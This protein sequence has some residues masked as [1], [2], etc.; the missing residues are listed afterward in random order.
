MEPTHVD[1]A[2][3]LTGKSLPLDHG[4]HLFSAVSRV[5]PVLH[6]RKSWGIHP[7]LGRR[8]GPGQLELT[9]RSTLKLRLPVAELGIAF[10]LVGK[11]LEV[12]GNRV[13]VGAPRVYPLESKPTLK[14]RFVT[15]KHH[16]DSDADFAAAVREQLAGIG[17]LGQELAAIEVV[18][19]P[20]RVMRVGG[21]VIVGFAV[22]LSGL[23]AQAS[24]R[25]QQ[26]GIGGRRHMG[27]GIFVPMGRT[28]P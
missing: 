5:L 14:A 1:A 13:N 11:T 26:A 24:L 15:I 22:S 9:D 17:D 19:G 12:G 8:S 6:E 18:V 27:A 7:V 4:Y 28:R 3:P 10:P 21:Q 23:L 16:A 2:F 25:I 20:R